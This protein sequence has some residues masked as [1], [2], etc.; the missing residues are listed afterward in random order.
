MSNST[1][2]AEQNGNNNDWTTAV[3]LASGQDRKFK[4]IRLALL[5]YSGDIM[6]DSIGL[7]Y[8]PR[9]VK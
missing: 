4:N 8:T 7:V 5:Q 1:W 9:R 3:E 6:V 2:T